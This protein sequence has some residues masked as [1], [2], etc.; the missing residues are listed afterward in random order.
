MRIPVAT[1]A[2]IIEFSVFHPIEFHRTHPM[3]PIRRDC[4]AKRRRK[5]GPQSS[6]VSHGSLLD[7]CYR[8][9]TYRSRGDNPAESPREWSPFSSADFA[10]RRAG[11]AA[12]P[13]NVDTISRRHSANV[14]R[15][16]V[17]WA[18]GAGLPNSGAAV[19]P[20]MC[21]RSSRRLGFALTGAPIK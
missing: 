4:R 16:V 20:M 17:G 9:K 7:R 5:R 15:A 8:H 2:P 10:R 14:N 1:A 3:S 13:D 12:L 21:P 6:R 18:I 19:A 11:I